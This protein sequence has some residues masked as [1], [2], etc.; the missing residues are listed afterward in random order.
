MRLP[1][2]GI[3]APTKTGTPR[4]VEPLAWDASGHLYYLW[5]GPKGL[6]LGLSTDQGQTWSSWHLIDRN[7]L[8]YY[9]YLIAR[10]HGEL[11]ATWHS[12]KGETLRTHVAEMKVNNASSPPEVIE[13]DPFQTEIWSWIFPDLRAEPVHRTTGGEYVAITFLREGGLGVVTTIQNQHD[14]RVGFVWWE[15]VERLAKQ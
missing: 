7:E 3:G 11:A 14:K 6:W 15:F 5:G 13:A 12:G 2:S 8:S 9:P 10:G 4:W 1:G